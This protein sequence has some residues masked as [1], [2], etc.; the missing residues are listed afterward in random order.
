MTDIPKQIVAVSLLVKNDADHFLL[1]KTFN[2]GWDLPGG[3][4]ELG[5]SLIDAAKRE[6]LEESGIVA[7]VDRLA[8]INAN[9]SKHITV[10][11]FI[12]NYVSGEP[13][14]SAETSESRWFSNADVL[15]F[16]D[17]ESPRY[18]RIRDLLQFENQIRYRA[19]TT[20]P[21]HIM[22]EYWI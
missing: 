16:V 3:Q 14:G 20:S 6:T 9:L 18:F 22:Q 7:Q 11:S 10:M 13:R 19:Y 4:V 1:V 21:F 8:S 15:R 17:M 12:G 5:E 2:R